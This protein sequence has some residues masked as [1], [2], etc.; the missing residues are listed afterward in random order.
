MNRPIP[1]LAALALTAGLLGACGT[2]TSTDD[3]SS[4]ES[5]ASTAVGSVWVADEGGDSLTVID[6]TTNTVAVTLTGLANPHNVQVSPD[7]TTIYAVQADHTLLAI[8]PV[9]YDVIGSA[10]TGAHPA[11]VIEAPNGKVYVTDSGD[12]TVSVFQAPGL[13]P[14]GKIQ[15]D[16]APHGLRPAAD[17]SVIV[18]ANTGSETLELIDPA[19]DQPTGAIPV[20]G[21]PVQV[22]VSADGHYAYAS[23]TDPPSVV[24]V[25]LTS[26]EVVGSVKV[27]AAPTQI[28]LTP[29]DATVLSADEG[30]ADRPGNKLSIIDTAAMS[31]R[32]TVRTGSRPHGVVVDAAGGH[33]W[34]TNVG[35]GTVSAINLEQPTAVATITVGQ[36]PAGISY[37]PFPPSVATIDTLP[38]E[39]PKPAGQR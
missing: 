28:V 5:A 13:Q 23:I 19:T 7:G 4:A 16:G 17:G 6:V 38:L 18:V 8:D 30:T 34:V 25:D 11:H 31:V 22:A 1:L 2:K 14:A 36:D 29:D 3:K 24:K 12:A 10:R 20:G 35:D 32:D 27:S 33:A 15:L 26:R 21:G 39:I 9:I 37:T